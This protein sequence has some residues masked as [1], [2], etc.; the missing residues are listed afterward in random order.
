MQLTACVTL[1]RVLGISK[2]PAPIVC[3]SELLKECEFSDFRALLSVEKIPA[4]LAGAIAVT[5]KLEAD[6]CGLLHKQLI[7]CIKKGQDE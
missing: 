5:T 3:E 2:K 6:K 1:S 7:Q 4:D